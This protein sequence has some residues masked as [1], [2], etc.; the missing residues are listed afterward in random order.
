MALSACNEDF[1]NW[2]ELPV[3]PQDD[4]V[5]YTAANAAASAGATAGID[6]ANVS[7]DLVKVV[8]VTAPAAP[9][10]G[11]T[12]TFQIMLG[13]TDTYDLTADGEMKADDLKDYLRKTFGARPEMRDVQAVVI[14]TYKASD[15]TV[16]YVSEAVVVKAKLLAPHIS[17][18]YYVVGGALGWAE[19]AA[20]KEQKFQHSGKD[21]YDDPYFT[22]VINAAGGDTWFAIGDDE[23]CDAIANNGDYS[24]LLGTTK[25]NGNKDLTG[26]LDVRTNLSDDGSWCV[27]AGNTLIKI[28]LNMMDYTYT[29]E[30]MNIASDYFLVGGPN[31][32]WAGSAAAKAMKFDHSALPVSEDPIFTYTFAGNGGDMWFAFGDEAALDAITNNSD[33]TQLF[34]TKGESTDLSGQFDRRY[35][36]GGDHSFCVDGQAKLY[37]F[38][39]NAKEMT[40]KI[41][42]LNFAEFIYEIGNPGWS[43]SRALRSP[44]NDGKYLGFYELDG[45]FKFKPN[46]DNWE[47]D[48]EWDGTADGVTGKIADNGGSN[49]PGVD[50]GFYKIEVDLVAMTYKLTLLSQVSIIGT[51]GIDWSNDIDLTWNAAEGCWETTTNLQVGEMKFRGNHNWDGDLDLGGDLNNLSVGGSNIVIN[52][53]GTYDVKLYVSYI[54]ACKAVITKK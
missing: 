50:K 38:T 39:I 31:S 17:S 22:I 48:W 24:K 49:M 47:G 13:G 5:T 32:D 43:E 11:V 12:P 23:A 1:G 14:T 35:N 25:G 19:S 33:W 52:E 18:A 3:N 51:A 37:R 53:A 54:G 10:A 21:V 6:F 28:T 41:E 29:I 36:L 46:R 2:P 15:K 4:V 9:E 42:A 30:P 40:Y 34:G 16:R 44:A 20:S 26:N 7:G 27:E 8:D 45:E